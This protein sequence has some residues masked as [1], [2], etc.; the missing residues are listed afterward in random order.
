MADGTRGKYMETYSTYK[1]ELGG[2]FNYFFMF[3]LKFGEDE[4]ILNEYC[5]KWVG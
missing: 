4:P 5:F 3:T 2:A 1:I